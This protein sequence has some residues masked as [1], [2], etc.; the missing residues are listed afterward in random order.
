M[1]RERSR[2]RSASGRK[3]IFLRSWKFCASR[4]TTG[5]GGNIMTAYTGINTLTGLSAIAVPNT[6]T[7]VVCSDNTTPN[8]T[9]GVM[10]ATF[11]N[12]EGWAGEYTGFN[13]LTPPGVTYFQNLFQL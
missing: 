3:K 6:G 9:N 8:P 1:G 12:M 4:Q 10:S 5:Q 13:A 2:S 7:C 11:V